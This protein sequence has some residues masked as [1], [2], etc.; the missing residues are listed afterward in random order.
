[1]RPI[2]RPREV[3]KLLMKAGV[4]GQGTIFKRMTWPFVVVVQLLSYV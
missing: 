2:D 3:R 1:M 4:K